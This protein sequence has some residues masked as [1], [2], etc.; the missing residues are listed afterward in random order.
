MEKINI[1]FRYKDTRIYG[2]MVKRRSNKMDEND[3]DDFIYFI[4]MAVVVWLVF[5]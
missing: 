2:I 1:I 3:G 5:F 4:F